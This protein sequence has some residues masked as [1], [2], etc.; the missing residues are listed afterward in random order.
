MKTIQT[1]LNKLPY[2][3]T[4]SRLAFTLIIL[5][6]SLHKPLQMPI[7]IILLLVAALLTESFDSSL[8]K[9]FRLYSVQLRQLDS[10]IDTFFWF[11]VLILIMAVY[12]A[13]IT[14]HFLQIAI[15]V[16]LEIL[17]LSTSYFKFKKSMA[18]HTYAAKVWAILLAL[19]VVNLCAGNNANIVFNI[20]FAWGILSQMEALSILTKLKSYRADVKSIFHLLPS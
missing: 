19:T 18:L 2:L 4:Y 17:V 5:L 14:A 12:P 9:K 20:A 8:A 1:T 15:L 7:A 3:L 16:L 10:K 11:S 13:F 6:M